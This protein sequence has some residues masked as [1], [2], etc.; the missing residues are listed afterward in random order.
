MTPHG[1]DIYNALPPGSIRLLI[2]SPGDASAE[3][4]CHLTPISLM[5]PESKPAAF[6]SY[7]ALSYTWGEPVFPRRILCRGSVIYITQNLFDALVQ[8]RKP[9]KEHALWIDALCINQRDNK[10]KSEQIPLMKYIYRYAKCV[11]IWLGPSDGFTDKALALVDRAA[12]L[13]RQETGQ[14]VPVAEDIR[15]ERID[16]ERN[17]RRGFPP[18]DRAAEW[19]PLVSLFSR[20]WFSRVWVF[21]ESRMAS[22]AVVRIGA[23]ER[24]WADFCAASSFFAYKSYSVVKGLARVLVRVVALC[25]SSRVGSREA[26]IQPTPLMDLLESTLRFQATE[27]RDRVFALLGMAVEEQEFQVNYEKSVK[28][29]YTDVSRYFL[30]HHTTKKDH[31]ALRVLSSVKHYPDSPNDDMPSWVHRWHAPIPETKQNRTTEAQPMFTISGL[32][33]SAKFHAGGDEYN[34]AIPSPADPYSISLKGFIFATISTNVNFLQMS[35]LSRPRLWDMV[36]DIRSVCNDRHAAYPTGEEID[37]ALAL[38]L[39]MADTLLFTADAHAETYHAIDFQHFC[40]ALYEQ[41]V[42]ILTSAG[43]IQECED[44]RL[45]WGADYNKLKTLVGAHQK[46]PR[47]S[48]DVQVACLGRELFGTQ[49]GYIGIGDVTLQE[50]DLVCVLFGGKVPFIL[51]PADGRYRFVGECYLHGIMLGEALEKGREK[52]QWFELF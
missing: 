10:E 36:L 39:T 3:L 8:L 1:G 41:T 45:G 7:D 51:R 24:D 2:L 27:P 49:E 9:D 17:R 42:T 21:Q 13:L 12:E 46:A 20:P 44:F 18:V 48:S 38:T 15:A 4:Q 6:T 5:S 22:A 33:S 40:L 43:R 25:A 29:I 50:G 26:E 32:A 30:C 37:E 16:V 31:H 47:F 23:Y 35:P 34:G 14:H 11:I 28:D 19:E 52:S